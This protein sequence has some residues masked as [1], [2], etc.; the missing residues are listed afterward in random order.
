[1]GELAGQPT[2][3][4]AKIWEDLQHRVSEV[5]FEEYFP[6]VHDMGLFP[7]AKY[8]RKLHTIRAGKR[9]RPGMMID[10]WINTRTKDQFR[11][12]PRVPV[13][14]VQ[15]ITIKH[16]FAKSHRRVYVDTWQMPIN[17]PNVMGVEELAINDGFPDVDS[18]FRW[19]DSDFEGQIIHWTDLKY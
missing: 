14:S 19:F 18:F 8:Q 5:D 10:F 11:F 4:V 6:Q 12:A 7:A 16:G 3:F 13:L 1:M 2:N 15:D 17:D 9:W